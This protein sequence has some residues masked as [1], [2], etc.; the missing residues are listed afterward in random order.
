VTAPDEAPGATSGAVP[1]DDLLTFH[2]KGLP[3]AVHARA[4]EHADG[5]TRE[6]ILAAAALR[7]GSNARDLP[8]RLVDLIKALSAQESMFTIGQESQIAAAIAADHDTIDLTYRLPASAADAAQQWSDLLEE[9]DDYCRAGGVLLTLATPADLVA[10]RRWFL[11]Q[12]ADQAAG[13]SPVSWDA[14]LRQH[15]T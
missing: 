5:L 10:Y 7:Q 15:L 8:A 12:F 9:A 3:L 14:H 1:S 4:Q 6:L 11:S 2:V 13:Q